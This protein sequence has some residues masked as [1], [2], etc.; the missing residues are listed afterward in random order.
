MK[1]ELITIGDELLLGQIINTNIA[2][3]GGK[4]A[5]LGLKLTAQVTVPDESEILEKAVREAL[6]RSDIVIT[7]GGLGPTLDDTTKSVFCRI[8]DRKLFTDKAILDELIRRYGENCSEGVR[9]Q[10][11]IPRGTETIPNNVGTAPGFIF[12]D[13]RRTAIV[14]PGPPKE[15]TPMLEETVMPKLCSMAGESGFFI[16]RTLRTIAVPESN[17]DQRMRKLCE[18]IEDVQYGLMASPGQVDIRLTCLAKSRQHAE[19]RISEAEI[20]VHNEFGD[21]IFG[22]EG[23]EIEEV[24]GKLLKD[25]ILTIA[26]AESCTGGLISSRLTDVLGSSDYMLG[27]V[28]SYSNAWKINILGVPEEIIHKHGAVSEQ[29]ARLMAEG[30]R[31]KGKSDLGLAVTGIAGPAGGAPDK[32]VG[33]VFMALADKKGTFCKKFNFPGTREMVKL[34]SSGIA[35]DTI[36]LHILAMTKKET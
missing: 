21:K 9:S 27:S 23:Q 1:I 15:L 30:V 7:T 11:T 25:N 34:K 35:L 29:T 24:V 32:P 12:E 31:I 6:E 14:L 36:R 8:F 3:I 33:L 18:N 22:Q 19:K 26:L 28:V 2:L 5:Q 13:G 16:Q 10:A 4:I 17:I 20:L